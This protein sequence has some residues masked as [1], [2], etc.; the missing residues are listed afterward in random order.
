M[1][2][3]GNITCKL[4][5]QGIEEVENMQLD[6]EKL[7]NA[8]IKKGFSVIGLAR[9]SG[10]SAGAIGLWL[11]GKKQPRMDTLGKVLNVLGAEVSDVINKED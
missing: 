7:R 9:A 1:P 8:M 10:V 3:Y 5:K 4:L 11:N 2:K 6:A